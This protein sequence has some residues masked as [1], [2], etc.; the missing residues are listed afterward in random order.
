M[1]ALASAWAMRSSGV[2]HVI[3]E[4]AFRSRNDWAGMPARWQREGRWPTEPRR[5]ALIRQLRNEALEAQIPNPQ[6]VPEWRSQ[7]YGD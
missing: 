3:N 5:L 6:I 7:W 1:L 4:H 2:H